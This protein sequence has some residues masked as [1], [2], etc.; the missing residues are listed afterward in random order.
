MDPVNY[1]AHCA[2][3]HPLL[4]DKRF[5]ESAPHREPEVVNGFVLRKLNAYIAAHPD[6]IHTVDEPDKELPSGPPEP[7]PR[8]A[9][10]WVEQHLSNAQ[11]RLWGKTCGKCHN[12]THPAGAGEL[13]DVPSANIAKQWL[14]HST[15]DHQAHQMVSC[16]SCHKKA[17]TSKATSDVLIPSVKVCQECHHS[18]AAAESR[19]FE[20]HTYH[21]WSKEKH[22]N[23]GFT[24]K[25][26]TD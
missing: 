12:L 1:R 13:P 6:Q 26:L 7:I 9:N 5:P 8:N 4:F 3:C 17:E 14:P 11:L 25:Q 16:G 21:D 19:C 22:V 18:G 10:E 23:G 20:C 15:F 24:V 2:A